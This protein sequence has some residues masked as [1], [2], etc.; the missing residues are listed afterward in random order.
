MTDTAIIGGTGFDR[1]AGFEV[2]RREAVSTRYGDPSGPLVFG[3]IAG[4]ALVFLPRH[5]MDHA[6]PPHR[7]NYRANIRALKKVGVK[8]IIA[9]FAVGGI[10]DPFTTGTIVIPDQIIDYTWGRRHTF[11][12][13]QT[14]PLKHID[15]STPYSEPLRREII[16]AAKKAGVDLVTG[17]TYAATQGPRLETAAEIDRL[18]RDGAGIVGMTGMP[19]AALARELDL[20]YAA[21]SVVVNPAAGRGEA[22]IR[23]EM[24]AKN[25]ESGAEKVLAILRNLSPGARTPDQ[26]SGANSR[27]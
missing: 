13:D 16:A 10:S 24:I 8:Q 21:I 18:E 9:L 26:P 3:R 25:I 20:E 4:R 5:G 1:L 11:F 12:D 6:I 27:G 2:D 17:A 15:F 14:D 7:V 22:G 19:E 23:I